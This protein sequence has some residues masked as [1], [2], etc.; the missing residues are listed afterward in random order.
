MSDL[1]DRIAQAYQHHQEGRLEQA[2]ASYRAILSEQPDQVD[3]LF[4]LSTVLLPSQ[5]E[6]SLDLALHALAASRGA[7]GMG[8]SEAA[9]LDHCAACLK[10]LDRDPAEEAICLVRAQML[11]PANAERLFLTAEAQRRAGRGEEASDTLR[12]YLALRPEDI[13]A[14]SNLGALLLQADR[15]AEA[16][17]TLRRV[18]DVEPRHLQAWI[19]LATALMKLQRLDESET[20]YRRALEIAPDNDLAT[21]GLNHVYTLVVP[22]W[23]FVMMNDRRRNEAYQSAIERAIRRFRETAGRPPLV[24]E[25]G[26]GS[27]LLSM[28]AA[29]AGADHV[30]AC[31]MVRPVAEAAREIIARNG[32]SQRITVHQK[33][34]SDLVVGI[35]LPRRADILVSEIFDAGLLGEYVLAAL[36]HA[37]EHL[38]EPGAAIVPARATVRMMAIESAEIHEY[39]RAD[40]ANGCGFDLAYFNRFAKLTYEQ[41]AIRRYAFEPIAAPAAVLDFDFT[42]YVP[43]REREMTLVPVRDGMLHAWAFWF[44]LDFDGE[45]FFDT[46]PF[47]ESTCWAQAVQVEARPRPV[48]RGEPLA[49]LAMQTRSEIHFAIRDDRADVLTAT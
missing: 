25:I 18:V 9:L 15:N 43:D 17:E 36:A 7:G 39:F 37:R 44:T 46:G 41:L 40:N 29:R 32:L 45:T 42:A 10:R 26:A 49:L 35:D 20:A 21:R 6:Q 5:P 2:R 28:M 3:V 33:K 23:H 11:E 19:N 13:N 27:G 16:A 12:R 14:R 8:V 47:A 30:V 4:L 31:E 38:L 24:L 34:S 48:R 1:V 22:R